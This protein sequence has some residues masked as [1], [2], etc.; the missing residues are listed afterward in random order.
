[1]KTYEVKYVNK[2]GLLKTVTIEAENS[3]E[4]RKAAKA[5]FA[6]CEEVVKCKPLDYH[7]K[8]VTYSVAVIEP[9]EDGTPV[10]RIYNMILFGVSTESK[11]VKD[12]CSSD[13]A[14]KFPNGCGYYIYNI[15]N[16]NIENV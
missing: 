10:M 12:K 8:A 6:D 3:I 5:G 7:R 4:A 9:Q 15:E 11:S 14:K 1:M 13:A 16:Y 2:D